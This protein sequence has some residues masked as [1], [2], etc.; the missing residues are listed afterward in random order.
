M[1]EAIAAAA[2]ALVGTRFRLH[3]RDPATGVDCV[4]VAA[5]A[6][7]QVGAGPRG[8]ALRG[9]SADGFAA[10]LDRAGLVRVA[11]GGCGD[12]ALVEAGPGQF[13]LLVMTDKGFVHADAAL[14]RVV[15]RPGQVPWRVIGYWRAEEA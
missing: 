3:G 10:M 6:C 8:Y 13:H 11:E 5:I 7:S 9:G 2:R 12:I 14:R 4:G 1:G 15:E